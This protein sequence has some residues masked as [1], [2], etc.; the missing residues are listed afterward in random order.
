[1]VSRCLCDCDLSFDSVFFLMRVASPHRIWQA[2]LSFA[3]LVK[4]GTN[5]NLVLLVPPNK[6]KQRRARDQFHSR[7]G[8]GS[9]NR[10][11]ERNPT[12]T[13]GL[14]SISYFNLTQYPPKKKLTLC[15]G[16]PPFP[17]FRPQVAMLLEPTSKLYK[18]KSSNPCT[19]F[20]IM[21]VDGSTQK[22]SS[23]CR[24]LPNSPWEPLGRA[25]ARERFPEKPRAFWGQ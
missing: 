13:H 3:S 16:V 22:S 17:F 1:M 12:S 9:K 2:F 14:R 23:G 21:L 7:L 4:R 25:L 15:A 8:C 24:K 11:P 18:G 19:T 20:T 5:T 10:D 6:R